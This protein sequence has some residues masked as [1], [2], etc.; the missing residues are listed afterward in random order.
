MAEPPAVTWS[1]TF[2]A[3]SPSADLRGDK[4]IL[5]QSALEQL[6]AASTN[7][8]HHP[9]TNVPA[10]F[11]AF[12]RNN[13]YAEPQRHAW[14]TE[15]QLPNPLMFRLVNQANGNTV[16]AGIREFSA[17]EG[18]VLLS[19]YLMEALGIGNGPSSTSESADASGK[20]D[21]M[22][23]HVDPATAPQIAV[24]AQQLP[25]GQYVRLRP[26]EAGYNPDDWKSLL[27]RQLRD[28]FTTLTNGAFL[29]VQGVR[30]ET[31]R[32]LIDVFRPE[33]DGICVV[34]TD[35][36]VDIEALNE[37]Q[38]R[39]TMRQI[40]AKAQATAGTEDESSVGQ[41]LNIW[42]D[43]DGRVRPG[44]YVDYELPSW[45]RSRALEIEISQ[46]DDE[47][48]VDLYASPKSS[49]Q[50]A[51]PRDWEHVFSALTFPKGES[52]VKRITISPTNVELD[53][54]EALLISVRGYEHS[55]HLADAKR[56]PHPF[57]LRARNITG[58]RD[59]TG[60]TTTQSGTMDHGADEEQ[61]QNCHQWVPKSSVVL[62]ENFC[63]RNNITCPECGTV[64]QKSSLEWEKHWHCPHD[65]ASG[66]SEESKLKHDDMYHS[67]HQCPACS[68]TSNS[69]PDLARHRTTICPGK[70]ILC[71]FCH[72][73][74]P[75]EG[76][77][78]NPSPESLLSGLSEHELADGARTTDCHL[79]SKI[80]RLRDMATHLK[81]HELEKARRPKPAICRN[82]N[83]GRT[84]HGVGRNGAIGTGTDVGQGPG[85]DIGLCSLC[86]SPLY[87]SLHDP[88]GKA[89][90]RRIERRYLSQMMTGC[91]K[92]WCRNEWCKTGRANASL[93]AKGASAQAVL[94]MVKP[95]V[96]VFR[97]K[98]APMYFCVDESNQRRRML[99]G[100]LA[101]ENAWDI[102][103]CVAACQAEGPD[104]DKAREWLMNWAPMKE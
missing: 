9:A 47:Y 46:L 65:D 73:E 71:K 64:F 99:A 51:L 80:I 82:A 100:M 68:F 24:R 55:S 37:E 66:S 76:D 72:L 7:A 59:D 58:N 78:F 4:I 95:L 5:P 48:S 97:D 86:F 94:P 98:Q 50:R 75:Q 90:K 22:D 6:L 57:R 89:L 54:A 2:T 85:N 92:K 16:Y 20:P 63:R 81:H 1:A 8:A 19:P 28:S 79:C 31:F 96:D 69:L 49:R 36:E 11:T 70:I 30:G 35:L 61:C 21:V 38:A 39:E 56:V 34:D 43:V 93:E 104:L 91:G 103:W 41:E 17:R 15:Q 10:S 74:V 29:S 14:Q 26:L 44:D 32:F 3:V 27:E 83:C 88:E 67:Q 18:E 84:L 62:H 40:M 102:E 53:E 25:K 23:A 87:V 45:A 101:S 42:K 13:P 60:P 33:G 12:D 77:P 52:G